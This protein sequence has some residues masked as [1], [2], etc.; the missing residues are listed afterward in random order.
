MQISVL[1]PSGPLKVENMENPPKASTK[2]QTKKICPR[3]KGIIR[4]H[5]AVST[6]LSNQNVL[7]PTRQE[8]DSESDSESFIPPKNKKKSF[9]QKMKAVLGKLMP[10]KPHEFRSTEMTSVGNASTLPS[11]QS[12]STAS[13]SRNDLPYFFHKQKRLPKIIRH[14]PL[15]QK[16]CK[17]G[18]GRMP[19]GETEE[20]TADNMTVRSR[21]TT[22]RMSVLAVPSGLQKVSYS[23]KKKNFSFA[24]KKKKA[25]NNIRHHSEYSVGKLQMQV[26]DLIETLADKTTKLLEQRH[27]ELRECEYL[28]NEIL[29]SAKQFQ[30]VSKKK[31]RK[32]KF[33]N[34][35]FPCI[36]CC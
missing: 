26:D 14:V 20:I 25:E 12:K 16:L 31:T 5:G 10:T 30:R 27:E 29:Q 32:Y 9:A 2:T 11:S 4:W 18:V 8:S 36:C 15:P 17:Q 6:N 23:P 35:C 7:V 3:A 13:S 21:R 34:I 33:K 28:G 19:Q 1:S 24:R 22:R